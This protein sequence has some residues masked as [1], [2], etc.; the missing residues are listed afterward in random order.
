M[1]QTC[2]DCS[3][4]NPSEA[5]YC[6]FDG[7][8]LNGRTDLPTD[9][10]SISFS[11]WVF[12]SPFVLPSGEAC[13]NFPSLARTLQKNPQGAGEV[14]GQGFLESFLGSLGRVDLALAARE[15]ARHP[16]RERGLDDFL[17]K[18]PGTA[19]E[20]AK[21]EVES[22]EVEL[23]TVHVGEERRFELTL[24]NGGDRLLYGQ[25]AAD[26]C[27][28][29]VLGE[30]GA[31]EKLFQFNDR[32]VIPVRVRG[33]R[34]RAYTKAQKGE[35]VLESNGGNVIVTVSVTVPIKP[36][37]DGVLAGAMTPRQLAEKAKAQANPAAALIES[38]A[39]ARWYET[40]G[41]TY[42]VQ[43]PSASGLAAVQ[44][45]F[46]ALGL[47]K[48]PKV[49][50]P[51]PAIALVGRAGERLEHVLTVTTP[52][53]R[54]VFAYAVSDQPWLTFGK[55]ACR[56]RSASIPL[57]VAAVPHEPGKS[58]RARVKVT[59]NGNQRFD[60]PLLLAVA[61]A[62]PVGGAARNGA[63][64]TAALSAATV[65]TEMAAA[66]AALSAPAAGITAVP[67][68]PGLAVVDVELIPATAPPPTPVS[69]P[70][71]PAWLNTDRR[72][73]M[74]RLLPVAVV[75]VGLLVTVLCDLFLQRVTQSAELPP[76]DPN[77][78]LVL[79]V[80][81]VMQ[82]N[83]FL[84]VP[85]MGP[86][87]RF[88]LLMPD[89]ID[90]KD[91]KAHPIL[92]ETSFIGLRAAGVPE[93]RLA[94]LNPLK[95]REYTSP[96]EF[97]KALAKVLD[98]GDLETLEGLAFNYA[99]F[100]KLTYDEFGRTSNTCVRIDNFEF[101]LGQAQG[102]RWKDP[103]KE[104]L[105]KDPLEGNRQR[106]GYKSTWIYTQPAITIEQDLEIVPGGLSPD[107]KFRLL[108]TCRVRY[109]IANKDTVV[110]KIGLRFLLD[111][112]IG[113]NDG[114][115]F[116][117]PGDKDLCDTFKDFKTASEVPD[118]ISALERQDVKNPGTVA[119]VSLKVGGDLE[120]PSRVTLGAW[121]NADL[122]KVDPNTKAARQNTG[123][124]VPVMSMQEPVLKSKDNPNGDSAVTLYWNQE[125]LARDK[126][127]VVGFAY[128]LGSVTGDTGK[129]TLGL[130]SG[131]ELIAEK[132]FTL[133]AYVKDPVPNQTVTL[134]LPPSLVLTAG[135]KERQDVPLSGSV[136][137]VTWHVKPLKSGKFSMTLTSSTGVSLQ[138][139]VAVKPKSEAF[140]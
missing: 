133:T 73:L 125:D 29:L 57:V 113:A 128:G 119:H 30:S 31:A 114:V 65:A 55:T 85:G 14:L 11:N 49:E 122:V 32:T 110:H 112:Y 4:V 139:W 134:S 71:G 115:P 123:W 59:A 80:H 23:G 18:L 12:P 13:R 44:Q 7:V 24:K 84:N 95:D 90:P 91:D 22:G 28:W 25:A 62:P 5:A 76:I 72:R 67:A 56:G 118:F 19:L 116:T 27:P 35:I 137:T 138:H 124:D 69:V 37:P 33:D 38:G 98:K 93:K 107:G 135:S 81:D 77:P 54:P 117:I 130:S 26:D 75:V 120:P 36:F 79:Q 129:G 9:G 96:D 109:A 46:E 60:V 104:P 47:V 127:R 52:E 105:G 82:P 131:G 68:V 43:G 136:S 108:D 53:N 39:V 63:H 8:Q 51:E 103:I 99:R 17:A 83:D 100:K 1:S 66:P 50:L 48:A 34:L 42:P 2:R 126:T 40:N 16:D 102:G 58:L 111:T 121:P 45:L 92:N 140:R 74:M 101:L 3:R 97:K 61:D 86:T 20:P 87:M 15:A 89:P 88:G 70:R 132:E 21:L 10:S 41:W 64:A 106:I 94:K 6:Y 78:R